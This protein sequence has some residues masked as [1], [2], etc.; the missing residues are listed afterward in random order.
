MPSPASSTAKYGKAARS[1]AIAAPIPENPPPTTA[2]S[3][4]GND[5]PV[6]ERQL[7]HDRRGEHERIQVGTT[8]A[9]LHRV[10]SVDERQPR[11]EKFR[12]ARVVQL[13]QA[14]RARRQDALVA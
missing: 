2:T 10:E 12:E 3:R 1:S 7:L 11:A 5:P 14:A 8:H 13:G 9:A 6:H 4:S